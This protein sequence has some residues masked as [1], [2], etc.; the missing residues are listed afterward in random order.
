MV[1]CQ[2]ADRYKK[3]Y[4]NRMETDIMIYKT[5][6]IKGG[7]VMTEQITE[8]N[9]SRFGASRLA[10]GICFTFEGEKEQE[11]AVRIYEKH[12]RGRKAA[13]RDIPVPE[14]YCVGAVRSVCVH[15]LDPEQNDYNYMIDGQEVV[16]PYAGRIVGRE[17]W[18]D[19]ARCHPGVQ[20]RSGFE[21][22][23]FDWK[24]DA[25]PEIPRSD[26][27]MYK[28]HV[29]GFTR[30]AG[31]DVRH[32]GTFAAI[33][34]RIGYLKELGITTV[35][36]M[37]AYE[38]EELM[39]PEHAE[40]AID[41]SDWS[42]Q[43]VEG[44]RML[45]QSQEERN[46]QPVRINY[47]GYGRGDY[48][49]PKA[50]YAAGADAAGEFKELVRSLH[51][52]GMECIMEIYF[53]AQEN[54]NY[55]VEVLRHWV[56]DYHVD[57]FHLIA[58]QRVVSGVVC[59][60]L[61]RRSKLFAASFPQEVW[62]A[63]DEYPHLYLYNDDFLYTSRKLIN[64]QD[65]NL[66]EF[67]NQ[68]RKQH[69]Q[70]GFVNY[71]A[72]NNGFTLA[73]VF[74]YV[75]KHNEAN[76]ENGT[77]GNDWNYSVNCGIEGASRK[78]KIVQQRT[79]L[80]S[81]AMAAVIFAQG[82]PLILA[83]DEFGNSQ[84]GNNNAYCQDNRTGW[85]NWKQKEKNHEYFET[86]RQLLAIRRAHPAIRNDRP[87][88]MCDHEAHGLPDLSYHGAQAW[89]GEIYPSMQ[90]LGEAYCGAYAGETQDLYIG[91]NFSQGKAVL[92]LPRPAAGTRWEIIYGA[93][94][95]GSEQLEMPD[96]GVT[97]LVSVS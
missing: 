35:E 86:V 37:P 6:Q 84:N 11:C 2:V 90:A 60:V 32:K 96:E 18:A 1:H 17:K 58:P 20:L 39:E 45:Q 91:W 19:P 97:V 61:L 63:Q 95:T 12:A 69:P 51:A 74:S 93:G 68:Q 13:Y 8:G 80:M 89:S 85:V 59:D 88:Q 31:K 83:G 67:F 33:V 4:A 7:I 5:D 16:D 72:N 24:H 52:A 22:A 28:L 10:D 57:G 92:A 76:G 9:Y 44:Y 65:G 53:D 46:E 50:G 21:P 55:A 87:V 38:F 73:D 43:A 15:G 79:L 49:A 40:G 36:L 42:P 78:K 25:H 82:V 34:E 75:N 30:D 77:D 14:E 56:I 3:M 47:W 81:Q 64:H 27:V 94:T 54:P 29:R 70:V 23:E 71:I 62:E 26:M 66:I 48:F 41:F